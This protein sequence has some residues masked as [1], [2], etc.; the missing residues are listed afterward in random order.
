MPP[1]NEPTSPI[2]RRVLRRA[3]RSLIG[4]PTTVGAE[5]GIVG[6]PPP[7]KTTIGDSPSLQQL[8]RNRALS[9]R[10]WASEADAS[11]RRRYVLYEELYAT[12][13]VRQILRNLLAFIFGGDAQAGVSDAPFEIEWTPS[14]PAET[15]EAVSRATAA[16]R[17]HMHVPQQV[18]E[19]LLKGDAFGEV[20]H[21]LVEVVGLK[22]QVSSRVDV[23]WDY[24]NRLAGYRLRPDGAGVG[25][26]AGVWLSPLQMVHYHPHRRWGHRY[27][28]SLFYG[29]P[30]V[31]RQYNTA[32]DVTH[33]LTAVSAANRRTAV[34][35][36]SAGWTAKEIRDWIK[37][38]KLW[39]A[40]AAFFDEDG[41]MSKS[42]GA[43]LD[44]AEKVWPYR[45]GTSKPEFH[46]EPKPPFEEL[47]KV[48]EFDRDRLYLGTGF[49][50]A[51]AGLLDDASGLGGGGA[52]TA[53]D[54]A[55]AR[56]IRSYQHDA[57]MLVLEYIARA[58]IIA[59][60]QID[61]EDV[62]VSM[63]PIGAFN[64]KLAAETLKLRAE[65]AEK[66]VISSVPMRWILRN[67]LR[68]PEVEVEDM[69]AAMQMG[70][71][72]GQEPPAATAERLRAELGETVERLSEAVQMLKPVTVSM[73]EIADLPTP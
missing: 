61:P 48:A 50:K 41:V 19:G 36:V 2:G 1:P 43:M 45:K 53:A 55:L 4:D 15:V 59:D 42:I 5:L 16:M 30:S 18:H 39:N 47:L 49:P 69:L 51:L 66:L 63:P 35:E 9:K 20:V 21:T 31:G 22:S 10:L 23:E 13:E 32:V 8:K 68:V 46:D 17:L 37:K 72:A 56:S 67:V 25:G 71:D 60:V 34:M 33:A 12:P 65:A 57:A 52:L 73:N 62:S 38:I 40:D 58:A 24:Y 7:E 29:L 70:G 6:G 28:E 11:R 27:G 26:D 64:E 54:L 3:I 14:A 44:F